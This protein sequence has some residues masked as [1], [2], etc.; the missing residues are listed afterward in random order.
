MIYFSTCFK[1]ST[2]MEISMSE[3]KNIQMN[4][5]K[6]GVMSENKLLLS[7]S[8]PM[9][10]SMLVQALYN[11]VDSLFV[12]RIDEQALTAVSYAFPLQTLIIALSGGTCVGINAL[13]SRALGEK[14]EKKVNAYA[15]NGIFVM[16]IVYIVFFVLGLLAVRPFYE[17]QTNNSRIVE[18]GVDYLTIVL[19]AS[20][21]ICMQFVFEKLLQSTGKTI[22]TM[23]TQMLGAIINLILDPILIFGLLGA[24]KMGVAGAAVATVIG[25]IAAGV[26]ALVL[27]L[28]CN[29]EIHF[30]IKGFRP[31]LNVIKQIYV[32]GLPSIIMQSIGSIMVV[33]MNA[34][35]GSFTE[36]AVAVFG[37]YF[38]MQSFVF[39]PIFGLNNGMVP[40]V[41]YN[42][43][44][45][46]KD[47]VLKV[48]KLSVMYA[49]SIMLVGFVLFQT[50]PNLMLKLFDASD[51][52]YK[53]GIPALRIISI[54]FIMAGFNIIGGT[55]FQA[56]GCAVYSMIT[57]IC[58]QLIVLL[59][60]A[61]ILSKIGSVTT[62][63]WAFPIA[64]IMA[65]IMTIFFMIRVNKN[66]LNK[67]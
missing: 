66:V 43:G 46:R 63:W 61:F 42:Y 21:G 60:A 24:P 67:I 5:N 22:H 50:I 15:M 59:P 11:I 17:M 55:M 26:L 49:M 1:M 23:F 4:E 39:M 3:E 36:T 65:F 31:S 13:L 12:A 35:L 62:V 18:Y 19:C 44:A 41:A 27:N 45:K 20:I 8:I 28:K 6:M 30:S 52:M 47:R 33:G 14:N 38:K 32:I 40:I 54:H 16:G 25:Q 34:I 29:K 58:R 56:L 53:I 48:V 2:G 7:M 51:N 57:S 64:E 10:I 37:I 9:M